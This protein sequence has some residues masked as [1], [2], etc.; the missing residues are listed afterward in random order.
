MKVDKE[1]ENLDEKTGRENEEIRHSLTLLRLK[2]R[3]N[4]T[5]H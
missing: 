4:K 5:L 3:E 2:E 1:A